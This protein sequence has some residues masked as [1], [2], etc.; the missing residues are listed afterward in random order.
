MKSS[1]RMGVVGC[2]Q[3]SRVGHGPAIAAD[4][5]AVIAACCDPDDANRRRFAKR[6]GVPRSFRRL[7]EMLDADPLDAVVIATP[8]ML[9]AEMV[10]ACA[11][12]VPAIL[13]EKPLAVTLEDCNRIIAARDRHDVLLQVGHSKR[14]ETGFAKIRQWVRDGLIGP[15]HQINIEWHYY[16]PDLHAGFVGWTLDRLQAWGI[17]LRKK[18]GMWRLEDS[19]SGGGDLFDH[20]PHYFDLLQFIFADVESICCETRK[21]VDNRAHEDMSVSLL[22]L[23]DGTVVQFAKSCHAVGRPSGIEVGHVYG[24]TGKIWFE[25]VQEYQHKP[26]RL[27]TYRRR[28]VFAD[29]WTHVRLPQGR[30]H[31]LYFRQMRHFIDRLTGQVTLSPPC[32]TPWAATAEDARL[33]L[34]WLRAAYHAAERHVVVRWDELPSLFPIELDRRPSSTGVG[35]R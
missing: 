35:V 22:T 4:A 21:L 28:N 20:G 25:A 5:R 1:L 8:P 11:E 27:R 32:E 9:H 14:F 24:Q 31:T 34:A 13:C 16:L 15:V 33:A 7:D 6:F 3:V 29:A 23:M 10:E 26:M 2:G 17:D 19:D 18:Y 12:R 30:R